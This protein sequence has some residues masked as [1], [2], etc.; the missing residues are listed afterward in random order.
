MNTNVSGNILIVDDNP[1]NLGVLSDFLSDRG[2]EIFVARDG[3]SALQKVAYA[4]PDLILLDVMMPGI[5]GFET[6]RQL[7]DKPDT[8][9]I[10]VIFMTALSET[11]DKVKGLSLGAVDYITKPFQQDEVLARVQLHLKLSQLTK[12]LE[13]QNLRLKQE[14][15]QRKTAEIALQTLNQRLE[16]CVAERTRE[17]SEALEAL[18]RYQLQVIQGE[19]LAALG[20]LVAG[21]AHEINNPVNF[22]YGNIDYAGNYVQD[23]LELVQLYQ[24]ECPNVTSPIQTMTDDIDLDFLMQDLP[25]VFASMKMGAE[26]IRGIVQ[27]LRAFSRVDESQCKE[28]DIHDGIDST[29]MILHNRIKAK[30]DRPEI[31][32]RKDYGSIPLVECY[33]GQLNQVFMN[34]IVNAIDALEEAILNG[35]LPHSHPCIQIRTAITADNKILIQIIDNGMGIPD[36]IQRQ[37]F[38]PFFT[39]KSVGKGT[40]L[41]LSISHQIITETHQGT[42]QCH[43]TP[44]QGTEF[45]IMIPLALAIAA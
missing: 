10:P 34:L 20:Q 29:L 23:L 13:E 36:A 9:E 42:L 3:A 30:P 41:G 40:G 31:E 11:T 37:I 45:V 33:P 32:I 43:S 7:K 25:K 6:C 12:T 8:A 4:P 28:V 2:F 16:E 5:D 15:E 21:V 44:H 1:N 38:D 22:I 27:S 17:L 14:V 26:R 18:Q 39:T 19:K 24:T 35:T